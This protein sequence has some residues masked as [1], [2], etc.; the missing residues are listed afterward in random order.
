VIEY[1]Q[2]YYADVEECHGKYDDAAEEWYWE[3]ETL[4]SQ[5]EANWEYFV[6]GPEESISMRNQNS[7]ASPDI[8]RLRRNFNPKP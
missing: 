4:P 2:D 8:M 3:D 7:V 6:S 1:E 5:E